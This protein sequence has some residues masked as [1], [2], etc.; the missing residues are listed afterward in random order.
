MSRIAL[1]TFGISKYGLKSRSMTSF[2]QLVRGVYEAAY[3]SE[4][5][6]AQAMD[7]RP[8]LAGEDKMGQDYG[9]WGT[10]E[11]PRFAYTNM[12]NVQRK[13][14]EITTLSIWAD[15]QS[16]RQFVYHGVHQTALKRRE[17][18]FQSGLWPGYVMWWIRD[19][20]IPTWVAGCHRLEALFDKGPSDESVT[21]STRS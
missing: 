15:L 10:Y 1:Y 18:W 9:Q 20:E 17:E 14:Q 3:K 5:F 16:A 6:V 8:D 2:A 19:D 4:G 11:V 21:F 12:S 13:E 7:A